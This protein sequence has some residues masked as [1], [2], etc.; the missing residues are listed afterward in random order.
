MTS[1]FG[2][3]GQLA[4]EGLKVLRYG[5]GLWYPNARPGCRPGTW[6][7]EIKRTFWEDRGTRRAAE[8]FR[9]R[10]LVEGVPGHHWSLPRRAWDAVHPWFQPGTRLSD[11]AQRIGDAGIHRIM[12]PESWHT[13]LFHSGSVAYQRLMWATMVVPGYTSP[14]RVLKASYG[15][16]RDIAEPVWGAVFDE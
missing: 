13:F 15:L 16:G 7:Q 1:I 6:L 3:T 5:R 8:N 14:W 12:L 10:W 9:S 4:W 2:G 11:I